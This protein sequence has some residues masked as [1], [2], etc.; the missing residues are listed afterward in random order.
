MKK[1]FVMTLALT[2]LMVTTVTAQTINIGSSNPGSAT[3]SASAAIAKLFA[4]SLK[5]QTRVIPHGGRGHP[6]VN[7]GEA[8]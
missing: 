6:A 3:H 8:D 4:D 2:V 1:V 7:A 5:T